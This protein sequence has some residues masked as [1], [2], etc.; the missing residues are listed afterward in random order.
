MI[1]QNKQ[2]YE[3]A[4]KNS[5]Y[6]EKLI[7]KSKENNRNIQIKSNNWKRR[8]LWFTPPCNMTVATKI[9]REFF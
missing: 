8:I 3:I 6:T 1:A 5:G 2:D 4:L 9:G 7:H